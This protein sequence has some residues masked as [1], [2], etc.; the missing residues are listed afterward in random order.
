MRFSENNVKQITSLKYTQTIAEPY[1]RLT[2]VGLLVR[3]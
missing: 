2:F 1:Q 3:F